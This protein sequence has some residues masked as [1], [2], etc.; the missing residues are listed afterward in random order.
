MKKLEIEFTEDELTT[1]VDWFNGFCF[2][3]YGLEPS[4]ISENLPEN[5]KIL[6]DRLLAKFDDFRSEEE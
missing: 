2:R 1:V 3:Y 5:H 4:E 6:I